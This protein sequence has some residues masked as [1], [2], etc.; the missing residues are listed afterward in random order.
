MLKYQEKTRN[1][2][3]PAGVSAGVIDMRDLPKEDVRFVENFVE[4]LR[5]KERLEYKPNVKKEKKIK[6]A[7]WDL[8]TKGKLG[9]DEIYDYL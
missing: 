6:F 1:Y 2:F 4:L 3:N 8:K 7:E 9:R 5:K